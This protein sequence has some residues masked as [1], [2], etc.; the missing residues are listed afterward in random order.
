MNQDVQ[1]SRRAFVKGIGCTS[2]LSALN[3]AVASRPSL[4]AQHEE[5]FGRG[6]AYIA[7]TG[8][9]GSSGIHVFD[10]RGDHWNWK[11]SISSR[12]PVSLALH[13]NR[14]YLY[15]ANQVDEYE[16]LPRGTVEAYKI[17]SDDGSL[18][19]TNR[20]PLS[21]SGIRPRHIAISL[22]GKY[23][24]AAIHGGGAYNVLQIACGGSVC[25]VA[26]I[27][28]VVGVGEHP[29]YQ[30]CSH[31][32]TVAFDGTGQYLLSTDEGCDRISAFAFQNGEMV[33]TLQSLA[34]PASRPAHL[35]LH[36]D[37]TFV[38]VSNAM[39]G[40]IDCYRLRSGVMEMKFERRVF[41]NLKTAHDEMHPLIISLSGRFLYA[42]SA[43]DGISVWEI[44]REN[45]NL[46]PIQRWKS[47]NR[48]LRI[49]MM[50]PDSRC[51]FAADGAQHAALSILV[52]SESGEL[53]TA[54]AVARIR[55]A[56]SL[57]VKYT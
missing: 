5:F 25:R 19:L 12:L 34:P 48:S 21:L 16:G 32:H 17:N 11:Q 39:D 31:P 46:A 24:I 26:Q 1:W 36:P 53:G 13:P 15:V 47:T 49:L 22:D 10:V 37:G 7:S 18:T 57:I 33:R 20:Q 35:A 56:R 38:Y 28:K 50:S 29:V 42:A 43:D 23:L 45:G 51:L 30:T 4:L 44:D 41:A 27:L 3:K 54:F 6:F 40:S 55:N 52:D 9:A 8:D 14:Q 2:V